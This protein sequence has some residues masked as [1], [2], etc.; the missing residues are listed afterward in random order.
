MTQFSPLFHHWASVRAAALA[1]SNSYRKVGRSIGNSTFTHFLS[2]LASRAGHLLRTISSPFHLT[3]GCGSTGPCSCT[4]PDGLSATYTVSG[5]GSLSPCPSCDAST[6]PPWDGVFHHTGAGCIWWA[7][8]AAFDPRS[9][10]GDML[11]ITYTQILL[12]TTTTPCRWEMYI[13]CTSV[14]NPTATM[15]SGYKTWAPGSTPAGTYSLVSSDCGN[16]TPTLT[17]A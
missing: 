10:N 11:D 7:A 16:T 5:L 12:R 17:V 3:N 13:A 4:W 15:W 14:I 8:D 1:Q 2:T 6:D 9:I